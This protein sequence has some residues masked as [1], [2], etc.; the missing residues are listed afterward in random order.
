MGYQD[1]ARSEIYT[2]KN[3]NRSVD[4]L[5]KKAASVVLPEFRELV[6]LLLFGKEALVPILTKIKRGDISVLIC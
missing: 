2:R 5:S 4:L 6:V 1:Q 3:L